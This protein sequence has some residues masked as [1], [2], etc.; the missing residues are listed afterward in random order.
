MRCF[1]LCAAAAVALSFGLA[2]SSAAAADVPGPIGPPP[3]PDYYGGP[4][5][6]EEY[7]YPP[8]P[9]AYGYPPPPRAYYYEEPP[10]VVVAP[11]PYYWAR[12]FG[13][14]YGSPYMSRRFAPPFVRGYARPYWHGR[15]GYYRR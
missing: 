10:P 1:T 15:G 12:P 4:P 6:Q 5:V 14:V 7:P 13:P 2:V 3:S 8:P 11:G 9:R